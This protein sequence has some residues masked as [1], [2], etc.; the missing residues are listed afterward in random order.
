MFSPTLEPGNPYY[1]DRDVVVT[2]IPAALAEGV[3]LS[4]QNDHKNVTR[5]DYLEF[6]VDRDVDIYVAFPPNATT[7]PGWM[8]GFEDTGE[9]LGVSAGTPT[10]KLYRATYGPGTVVLGGPRAAGVNP[11]PSNNYIVV[12]VPR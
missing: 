3:F 2:D 5:S 4:T 11:T 10:L 6:T 8:G 9:S 12:V 7:V 1:V